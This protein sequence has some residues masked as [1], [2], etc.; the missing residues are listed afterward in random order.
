M[1][2]LGGPDYY[3]GSDV[4]FN[5]EQKCYNISAKTYIKNACDHIKKLTK[6]KLNNYG[7][8]LNAGNRPE[9]DGSDLFLPNY[10]PVYQM[11]IG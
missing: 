4:G 5:E 11:L 6:S 8:P 9:I 2:V 7:S 3:C 10:I 1:K